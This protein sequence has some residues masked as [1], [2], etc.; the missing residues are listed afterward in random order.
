MAQTYAQLQKQIAKLQQ[1]ADALRKAEVKGVIDRI[2][3]AIAHYALTAEQLGFAQAATQSE[4][5]G[6][7]KARAAARATA[8][9]SATPR[10]SNAEGG[11]WSGRGARPRWLREALAAGRD[12]EDFSVNR[13]APAD[14]EPAGTA[15]ATQ[16][17][18]RRPAPTKRAARKTVPE[19]TQARYADEAGHNWSGRGPRPGWL[20]AQL[21]EGKSLSDFDKRAGS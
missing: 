17:R 8:A 6:T 11:S 14:A 13:S 12:L 21:A 3:V 20:K 4:A 18:T 9:S 15:Q 1:Q 5:H 10:F 2:K 19:A 7:R 16:L